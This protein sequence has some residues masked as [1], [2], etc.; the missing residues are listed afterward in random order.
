[1]IRLLPK[2]LGGQLTL[3]LLAALTLSH[4]VSFLIFADERRQAMRS[5]HHLELLERT[6]AMVRVLETTS[7][8][9]SGQI[10]RAV[11]S[12]RLRYWI[13]PETAIADAN[14]ADVERWLAARLENMLPEGPRA[15]VRVHLTDGGWPHEIMDLHHRSLMGRSRIIAGTMNRV[16]PPMRK[17]IPVHADGG[18]PGTTR[19]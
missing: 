7:P 4:L 2:S 10:L 18:D 1:M 14:T 9:M 12:P 15:A 3:L 11:G 19:D 16:A 17:M 5:V 8:E 13:T 6:A